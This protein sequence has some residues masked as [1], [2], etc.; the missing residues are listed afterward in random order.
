LLAKWKTLS[1]ISRK[2]IRPP[3]IVSVLNFIETGFRFCGL[4][5]HVSD[6]SINRPDAQCA[7][8]VSFCVSFPLRFS[9]E[10]TEC[11]PSYPHFADWRGVRFAEPLFCEVDI[12]RSA[13]QR[14]EI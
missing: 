10:E 14:C 7:C 6:L 4:E 12:K 2:N 13:L 11:D 3:T 9:K 5:A 1:P 8:F